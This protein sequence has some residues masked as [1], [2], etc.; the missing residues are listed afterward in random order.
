MGTVCRK[1][2]CLPIR[3][4]VQ[5]A[6]AEMELEC[7]SVSFPSQLSDNCNDCYLK[8]AEPGGGG[9]VRVG[10]ACLS[11][12]PSAITP[13]RSLQTESHACLGD[14]CSSTLQRKLSPSPTPE[15]LSSLE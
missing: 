1:W 2:Q 15:D 11:A 9:A 13:P 10:W 7:G 12:Y 6:M 3:I 8:T 4:F 5:G 14:P